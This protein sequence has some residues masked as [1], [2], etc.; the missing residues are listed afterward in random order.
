M[1][2]GLIICLL[3]VAENCPIAFDEL[4]NTGSNNIEYKSKKFTVRQVL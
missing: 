2:G 3:Y 1:F 4:S